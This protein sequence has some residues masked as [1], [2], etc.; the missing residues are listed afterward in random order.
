MKLLVCAME[1]SSN[2]HLKELKKYL[3]DDVELYGVFDKELGNP[4]YDL[5]ALAIMGIVDALKKLRFFFKLRDELVTLAANCDKVL[6][7]DSSGFNL[8][9]AKKLRE[10]YPNKEIIYYILPQAWAWKKGRVAKLEKYCSKLCSII[11]F[12]GEMYS[13]KNKITYVGHP[14]LDEIKDF[15]QELSNTNKIA[16]MPGSRKTEISN[17]MPIFKELIKK[18]PNKE[19]ILI[20]PAKFDEEYIKKIYGDI[21]AFTISKNT[22][23][24][25]KDSE[26]AF[27]CS[28]TATLEAALIGTP[29]T[30]SYIAKKIDYFIGRMFVKLNHVGLANIFF[31]KMGKP[32]LHSEFLQENV[33]LDNLLNDYENIDKKLFFENSRLLRDYLKNGSSQNV[34]KIIQN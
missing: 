9:L 34:A 21:S 23:E 12:E 1:A 24:A 20:I 6:L 30:L 7:M 2:I 28:G 8:P 33:S 31:E 19:Y 13:D 4:L 29:F 17:L 15:K 5:T 32:A 14:L 26:Y 16:F 18:I 11:P 10:T 27:I 25:L 22:H 3:N